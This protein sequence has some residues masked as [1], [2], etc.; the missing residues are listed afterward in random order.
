MFV[1]KQMDKVKILGVFI[2][3]SLS[4]LPTINNIVSKVTFRM[5]ILKRVFKFCTKRTKIILTNSI[6]ISLFRYSAPILL[7]PSNKYISKLQKMLMKAARPI[8]GFESYKWSTA[9]IMKQL[10]W[11]SI[12]H[13][14]TAESIKFLHKIYFNNLPGSLTKY[15]TFSLDRDD[16]NRICRQV[17]V[18]DPPTSAKMRQSLFL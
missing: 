2:A 4:N 10:N 5:L 1:I 16:N 13:L 12:Y 8:L 3:A 17:R 6:I 11:L 15:F 18:K 7:D 14:I 9:K